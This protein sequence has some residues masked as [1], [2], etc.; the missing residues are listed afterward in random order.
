MSARG[1]V[2]RTVTSALV[3]GALVAAGPGLDALGQPAAAAV[4]PSGNKLVLQSL[5]ALSQATSFRLSGY[6]ERSGLRTGILVRSTERGRRTDG[7][8]SIGPAGG[9]RDEVVRFVRLPSAIY[10]AANQRYWAV[11]FHGKLS[12]ALLRELGGHWVEIP[13]SKLAGLG[14][15]TL[16]SPAQL[17][18]KLLGGKSGFVAGPV[19]RVRGSRARVILDPAKQSVLYASLA[20]SR[21]LLAQRTRAGARSALI[22]SYPA[23]IHISAPATAI[24]IAKVERQVGVTR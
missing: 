23:T 10:M 14:L 22:F 2:R 7:R 13:A 21:P 9:N 1:A 20:T 17:A 15:G 18:Q 19:V 5:E 4:A 8:I 3:L 12:K 11:S 6:I 16:T 24:P